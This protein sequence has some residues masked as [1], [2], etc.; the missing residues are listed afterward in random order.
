MVHNG[1]RA[2]VV[3]RLGEKDWLRIER[4]GGFSPSE[5]I[6]LNVYN[7]TITFRIVEIA[8]DA[9]GLPLSSCLREFGRYWIIF[10]QRGAFGAIMDFTGNDLISFISNLDRMH[11]AVAATMPR[12][13]MPSFIL[14]EQSTTSLSILYRSERVGLEQFVMGLLE[15][16]L[17]RFEV[18]GKVQYNGS[19][20]NNWAEFTIHL[21]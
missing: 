16:L 17:D 8:A 4:L 5:F 12:G 21:N 15:G 9:L 18:I 13:S 19:I 20:E 10:A 7:D 1:I 14:N 11:R 3:E 6:G 2:M